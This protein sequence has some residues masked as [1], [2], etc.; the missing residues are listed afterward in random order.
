[1][2]FRAPIRL[3]STRALRQAVLRA[4]SWLA[5]SRATRPCDLPVRKDARCVQPT[6]AIR[7]IDV[8][9]RAVRSR[10]SRVT[11]ATRE[12]HDD[13]WSSRGMTEGPGVFTTPETASASSPRTRSSCLRPCGFRS[14]AWACSTRGARWDETSD[15]SVASPSSSLRAHPPSCVLIHVDPLMVSGAR[16]GRKRERPA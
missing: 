2:R 6:S 16:V 3:L 8:H 14:R 11:F 1:M 12:A 4:S 5:P 13:P 10:F 7:T 15:T 9:P